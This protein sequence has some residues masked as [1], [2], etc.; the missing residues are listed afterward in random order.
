MDG[1]LILWK[2]LWFLEGWRLDRVWFSEEFRG[3]VGNGFGGCCGGC[4]FLFLSVLSISWL[5]LS[6]G[7]IVNSK[8]GVLCR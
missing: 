8:F 6:Y 5:N 4:K 1:K 7:D 2:G 3:V